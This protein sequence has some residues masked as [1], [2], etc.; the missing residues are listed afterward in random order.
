MTDFVTDLD[1]AKPTEFDPVADGAAEIRNIKTVLRDTFP[2]A[3]TA[4]TVSNESIVEAVQK[5]NNG[6]IGGGGG[7]DVGTTKNLFAAVTYDGQQIVGTANNV[8]AVDWV[9]QTAEGSTWKFA[10]VTFRDAFAGLATRQNGTL[11]ANLNIQVTAFS[12]ASNSLGFAG[13][14]FGTITEI[15]PTHVEVA[16]GSSYFDGSFQAC[17]NQA[18]CLI[19]AEN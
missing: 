7:G 13:F 12:N 6:E 1:K 19:V 18:F 16:F 3:N 15:Y 9:E 11:D 17:W 2:N 5:V 10:R 4:L 14:V 8:A